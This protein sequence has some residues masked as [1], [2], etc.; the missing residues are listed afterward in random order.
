MGDPRVARY[1]IANR[2]TSTDGRM[3]KLG[4]PFHGDSHPIS[5]W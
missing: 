5:R 1:E 4:H 3:P 2:G